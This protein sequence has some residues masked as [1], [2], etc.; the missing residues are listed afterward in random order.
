MKR[1]LAKN[2]FLWFL[3]NIPEQPF[4]QN[5]SRNCFCKN[6]T[7]KKMKL[8]YLEIRKKNINETKEMKEKDN[9]KQK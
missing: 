7:R 4:L 6:V 8:Q 5:T 9:K 3:R 2:I 1:Y